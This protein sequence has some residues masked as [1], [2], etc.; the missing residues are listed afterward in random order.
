MSENGQPLIM[1]SRQ[2]MSRLLHE[3]RDLYADLLD[4]LRDLTALRHETCGY[5]GR[6]I[7]EPGECDIPGAHVD[8]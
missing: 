6:P 7:I 2:K 8:P 3:Q 1:V 4:S 5:C